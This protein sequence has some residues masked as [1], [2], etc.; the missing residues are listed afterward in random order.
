VSDLDVCFAESLA[1]TASLTPG[2]YTT[3]R[4]HVDPAWIEEALATTGTA[5]LRR[6]GSFCR[7]R[8]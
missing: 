7:S 6:R 3:F 5:T 8:A 4:Q 1:Y 2:V